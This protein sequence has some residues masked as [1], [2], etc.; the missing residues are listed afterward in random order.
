MH[1][2]KR[3]HM[4]QVLHGLGTLIKFEHYFLQLLSVC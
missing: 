2:R 4:E 1:V 3:R